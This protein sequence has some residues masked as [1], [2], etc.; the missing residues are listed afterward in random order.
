MNTVR[1][2][3]EGG[4]GIVYLGNS[5]RAE[6]PVI[7]RSDVVDVDHVFEAARVAGVQRIVMSLR[8]HLFAPPNSA[9]PCR[10][11]T[12]CL[13][14]RLVGKAGRWPRPPPLT[15]AASEE[16]RV[17]NRG[18]GTRHTTALESRLRGAD[19]EMTE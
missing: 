14:A 16:G 3:V 4:D 13:E 8:R 15:L 12:R 19:A 5:G 11:I 17:E 7:L 2:M 1:R 9:Q 18:S 6:W 10:A